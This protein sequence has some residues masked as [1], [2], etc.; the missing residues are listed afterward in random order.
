MS[1]EEPHPFDSA[2]KLIK[3]MRA[4]L[5]DLRA[6][7][8]AE[9]QIR[10][11]EVSELRNEVKTLKEV[12]TKEKTE[13]SAACQKLS[14]DLTLET[15]S[16]HKSLDEIKAQ[17]RQQ[18]GQ[19]NELLQDEVRERKSCEHVLDTKDTTETSERKSEDHSLLQDLTSHKA[20]FLNCKDE[21]AGRINNLTHDME[22]VVSYLQ[23]VSCAWESMKGGQLLCTGGVRPAGDSG[24]A[25]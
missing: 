6:A 24:Q 25:S 17:H 13:R 4:E 16:R 11:S 23:K 14:S 2:F 18:I 7:L 22:L 15:S 3:E 19:L 9:Q 21:H 1:L 20:N 10:A 5:Q 8:S 12:L